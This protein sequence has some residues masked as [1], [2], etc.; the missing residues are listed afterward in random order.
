M[1]TGASSANL[2]I[3]LIDARKGILEQT[4]RHTFIASLL[5]IPHLILCINKMDLVDFSE[6]TFNQ[7]KKEFCNFSA[8]LEINDIQYIPISALLGD[9]VVKTSDNMKW[10]KGPSLL[11][12]L[13]NVHIS[14]DFNLIDCRF[15][16]QYVIPT[17]NDKH[18]DY[19]AYAG[20][21]DGGVFK[22]GD[23]VMV[24]PSKLTTTIKSIEIADKSIQE[25][26]PP[27]SVTM[28][29]N[30]DIDISRGDMIVREK[31]CPVISQNI[32]VMVCWFNE[33]PL[34]AGGRYIIKHTTK[35]VKGVVKEIRYKIDINTLH[36]NEEDKTI[37]MN[38]F[39][40]I[41]IRTTKPLFFDKYKLNRS[42]G[43]IIFIDEK[44]NETV[45]AGMIL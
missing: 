3:V 42:T 41:H 34:S 17:N 15:P 38:E 40:R 37:R 9:N 13:E 21:I 7:I 10:Y 12:I 32:E 29:L 19:R 35:E 8:K 4:K 6:K 2:A 1:V 30:D 43:S 11:Y 31:N 25:A 23:K 5:K 14:S 27:M 45:G 44:T 24:L 16:V 22:P 39:A 20:R 28:A 36:R 26:F 33:K 18:N